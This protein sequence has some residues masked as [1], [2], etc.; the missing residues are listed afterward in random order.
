MT[1]KERAKCNA[2]GIFTVTQLSYGYRPR[3][4]KRTRP[5]AG[6]STNSA[7]RAASYRR[8][9]SSSNVAVG[10]ENWR[11]GSELRLEPAAAS[12]GRA[13]AQISHVV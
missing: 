10:V 3:R 5:D 2:E 1:G 9:A 8:L 6:R 13:S 12:H 11:A 4:R 7:K